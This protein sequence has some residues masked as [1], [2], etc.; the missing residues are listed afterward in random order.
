MSETLK[1]V[2]LKSLVQS[3]VITAI[4]PLRVNTSGYPYVTFLQGNKPNN[5]YFSKKASVVVNGTFEKGDNIVTF[6][7]NAEI[8]QTEVTEENGDVKVRFKIST[9]GA[10]EYSSTAELMDVFGMSEKTTEFDME[11]FRNQFTSQTAVVPA[12]ST[13]A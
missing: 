8:V 1:S 12:E 9:P 3:G 6:L 13:E 7:K 10:S 4:S 11:L 2:T 5:V